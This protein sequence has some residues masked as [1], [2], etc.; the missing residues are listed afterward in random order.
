VQHQVVPADEASLH[1]AIDQ[2]DGVGAVNKRVVV[3]QQV[4]GPGP[5]HLELEPTQRPP[6]DVADNGHAL[7]R[8]HE[9]HRAED[10]VEVVLADDCSGGVPLVIGE[11]YRYLSAT[12]PAAPH[13]QRCSVD[14]TAVFD[15]YA[16]EEV[17]RADPPQ[18]HL[19]VEI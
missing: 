4:A 11:L 9:Q 16:D 7:P 10:I 18:G 1:V 6:K 8:S 14:N 17:S 5:E 19:Q 13:D 15:T 2:A 12:E 3:Q